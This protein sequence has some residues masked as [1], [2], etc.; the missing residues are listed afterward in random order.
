M[1]MIYELV[2][3]ERFSL[4]GAQ[5]INDMDGGSIILLEKMNHWRMLLILA[6]RYMKK[7]NF[8]MLIHQRLTEL[9]KVNRFF[10]S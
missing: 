8:R 7:V 9:T 5:I 1:V 4:M 10:H 3:A 2:N 6:I